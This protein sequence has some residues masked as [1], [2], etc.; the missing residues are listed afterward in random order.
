MTPKPVKTDSG[1]WI[2]PGSGDSVARS[3]VV[4]GMRAHGMDEHDFRLRD[5][6]VIA[7]APIL[8]RELDAREEA[9]RG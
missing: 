9:A 7:V 5:K 6:L 8:E 3:F 2:I 4:A 1:V